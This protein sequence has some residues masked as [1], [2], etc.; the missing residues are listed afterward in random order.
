MGI[1]RETRVRDG[2]KQ[3]R[4]STSL[5]MSLEIRTAKCADGDQCE[6]LW[7]EVGKAGW[8]PAE[9]GLIYWLGDLVHTPGQW[10]IQA[11]FQQGLLQ[12]GWCIV[13]DTWLTRW[14][15]EGMERWEAGR[16]IKGLLQWSPP[17]NMKT[18]QGCSSGKGRSGVPSP[19]CPQQPSSPVS[20]PG[21]AYVCLCFS[22]L[23]LLFTCY[24]LSGPK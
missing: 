8:D 19:E 12:W 9:K 22:L 3:S 17:E 20:T 4:K 13:T 23:V 5:C 1:A 14:R 15:V 16:L 7:D 11:G 18:K 24:S 21:L 10:G 2:D 6:H